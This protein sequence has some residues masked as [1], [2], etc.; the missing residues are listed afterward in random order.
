MSLFRR[1]AGGA[2][3]VLGAA[4]SFKTGGIGGLIAGGGIGGGTMRAQPFPM[5]GGGMMQTAALGALPAIGSAVARLPGPVRTAAR[6]TFGK[7][8][9]E[10]AKALGYT[11]VGN[12]VLDQF[13]NMVG[14]VSK[15]RRI[16]PLNHRA[17][18]RAMTRVCAAKRVC[19]RVDNITKPKPKRRSRSC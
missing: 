14:Q 6:G 3:R 19:E 13:G 7:I 12:Q 17:L 2:R 15:R 16:N 10:V 1:I 4:A 9:R 8:T 5:P 18:G 11:I